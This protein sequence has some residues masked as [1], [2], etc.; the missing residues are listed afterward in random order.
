LK[1]DVVS[2]G[3]PL[4]EFSQIPGREREYLQGF[5]G[6]TSN[7][8]IAAARLGARVAYL[9]RVG[10][11]E[12]GRQ[13]LHLWKQ[14]KIDTSGVETDDVSHTA[15]YFISHGPQGHMFSYL[16][17]GSAASRMRPDRLPR[18]FLRSTRFFHASG[19][20]QAISDSAC[21]AVFAAIETAK[22]AGAQFVYDANVRLRLWSA[23]R[24]AAVIGAT[25]ALADLFFLSLEDAQVL[26]H[27]TEP[28]AV[29]DWCHRRGAVRVILKLGADG[30]IASDGGKRWKVDRYRVKAVDA[31]GAGDCFAGAAMARLAAGDIMETALRYASAA[32][33]LTCTGFGAV[34]PLPGPDAVATLMK[35]A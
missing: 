17:T 3:E 31:T 9:T 18:E 33:A 13:F 11:D 10:A 25:A 32:A 34:A 7:C 1:F 12:F 19:I 2:L 20:S 27:K 8:A 28:D 26:C 21:D 6:D 29:L 22:T 23:Q 30:A 5:G 4:Y 35:S 16:R 24:A 15:V 14:E